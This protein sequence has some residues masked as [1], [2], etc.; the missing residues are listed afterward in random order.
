MGGFSRSRPRSCFAQPKSKQVPRRDDVEAVAG[1]SGAFGIAADN[2]RKASN[3]DDIDNILNG[4]A[5]EAVEAPVETPEAEEPAKAEQ[6][7]GPDGKFAPKGE[8]EDAPPASHDEFD[9]KATLAE[10]RKR[11]EAEQRI[12]ALEAQLQQI[13]NPPQ[14]APD[15]FENPEGWQGHFGGQI[16]QTAVQE[17]SFN[18]LLNTSE[19][20]CR[21]KFDDFEEAKDK[22]MALA[23]GNPVLAQ[24]ALGD[25]HPW[26]KA[27]QIVKNHEKMEALGATD[28]QTLEAKL[29]EQIRAELEAELKTKPPVEIPASLAGAQGGRSAA[30][31]WNPP[32]LDQILGG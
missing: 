32:T 1:Q 12:A 29:R 5:P 17:A 13:A 18:A 3:M 9:G 6:P 31:V 10:R 22:F 11:Q 8:S 19:M 2:G 20:L 24:Q 26:R 15:M 21:D 27:Y 14:P 4:E 7:R 28:A 23:E 25:P 30:G 16:R